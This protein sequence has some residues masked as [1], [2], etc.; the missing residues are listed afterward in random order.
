MK[1]KFIISLMGFGVGLASTSTHA[2]WLEH[3]PRIKD[4]LSINI[5]G[6]LSPTVSKDI[7]TFNYVY[8]DPSIYNKTDDKGNLVLGTLA[9]VLKDQDRHDFDERLRL[10]QHHNSGVGFTVFQQVDRSISVEGFVYLQA[11]A[12]ED[13]GYSLV[14]SYGLTAYHSKFG[15]AELASYTTF[16]TSKVAHANVFNELDDGGAALSVVYEPTPKLA[17]G[18][19]YAFPGAEDTRN[20][21][22][23][24]LHDGHGAWGSYEHYF[25]PRQMI[26]T[27][28]GVAKTERLPDSVHY[29]NVEQDKTAYGLGV[30]YRHNDWLIDVDSTFSKKRFGG[31]LINEAD[32]RTHSLKLTYEVTPRLSTSVA[33]GISRAN[34]TA[35]SAVDEIDFETVRLL[36]IGVSEENLF[37]EIKKQNYSATAKY[38]LYKGVSLQAGISNQK[39]TN[40]LKEGAFSERNLRTYNAGLNFSF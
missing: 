29:D 19:F 22:D 24:G 18:G 33:Y 4:G 40:Y 20:K 37:K 39:T 14:P 2:V 26:K 11:V 21:F 30:S 9:Q 1:L 17:V 36:E 8:G 5:W 34:K 35:G 6:G 23:S 15:S 27:T 32:T 10:S 3:N 12:G 13:K 31:D 38:Q 25:A 7:S 16:D 28:A